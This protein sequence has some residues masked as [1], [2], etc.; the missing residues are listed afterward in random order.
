MLAFTDGKTIKTM[1]SSQDHKRAL[2]NDQGLNTG[3][4]EHFRPAGY[5][6]R[7]LTGTAW[8]ESTSPRLRLWRKKAGSLR[9]YC[10]LGLLSQKTARSTGV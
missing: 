2:D 5:I 7:K 4:M 6:Q 8:K 9:E 1:V 3:G 10:T